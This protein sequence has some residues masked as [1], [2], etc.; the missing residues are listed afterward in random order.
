MKTV[1]TTQN[2]NPYM[3][4]LKNALVCL[5]LLVNTM[6]ANAQTT[7]QAG[8]TQSTSNNVTS[9]TST[10]SSS[11]GNPLMYMWNF[12]D[13]N[14]SYVENPSHSYSASGYYNVTLQIFDSAANCRSTTSDSVHITGVC[15][16]RFD[17]GASGFTLNFNPRTIENDLTYSWNFGDGS[18]ST[19]TSPQ[20]TYT[21]EGDYTVCLKI[22]NS[23]SNC[24]DSFCTTVKVSRPLACHAFFNTG[25][26]FHD[27]Q[28]YPDTTFA[29]IDSASFE[30]NFGDGSNTSTSK[31]PTHTYAQAGSYSVCLTVTNGSCSD[32][33]CDSIKIK[34]ITN[35]NI[36][37]TV[38]LGY[39]RNADAAKVYLIQYQDSSL[40]LIDTTEVIVSD[41][42]AHFSFLDKPAG[43]Y[44]VKAALTTS[45]DY[46][47]EYLPTYGD[48]GLIWQN[49]STL[50]LYGDDVYASIHMRAGVNP[51]GPGFIGGKVSQGAN[52]KEGDPLKDIQVMLFDE[53]NQPVA[54]TYSNAEGEFSFKNLAF[55]KYEIYTEVPG[56]VTNPGFAVLSESNP[57]VEDVNVKIS[58]TGISTS[59]FTKLSEDFI[60]APQLYPNPAKNALY[61]ETELRKSQNTNIV[62]YNLTGQQVYSEN[63]SLP[64]GKQT[65]VID[66]EKLP[67]GLYMLTVKNASGT[68]EMRYKFVKTSL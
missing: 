53:N 67:A 58:A 51:G 27:A 21:N 36:Y 25:I 60:S 61:F 59:I 54:Y 63:I 49:S 18:S 11:S 5:F 66:T 6:F 32:I 9:F 4:L 45:S 39:A 29:G 65:H 46:Y 44:M 47:D 42:V 10:S 40:V 55:G 50:I 12:G 26:R 68:D 14:Y 30:W 2:A 37:G 62:I 56:L 31:F 3:L 34:E 20:H 64:Q 38:S 24:S 19:N 17:Y 16:A 22:E 35:S 15:N 7:C 41:T 28:F 1:R 23:I 8:F 43:N 48:T 57:K 13:N 33:F 52:K